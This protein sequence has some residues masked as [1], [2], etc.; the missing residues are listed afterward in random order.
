[1][2]DEIKNQLIDHLTEQGFDEELQKPVLDRVK[3][4][5]C[6]QISKRILE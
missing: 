6:D 1:M 4:Y 3:E 5:V 2:I